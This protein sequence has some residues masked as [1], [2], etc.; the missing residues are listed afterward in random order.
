[1]MPVR[2]LLNKLHSLSA[3]DMEREASSSA[4]MPRALRSKFLNERLDV[5]ALLKSDSVTLQDLSRALECT[6]S[7]SGGMASRYEEWQREF[8]SD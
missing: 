8:G 5:D 6:K 2:R 7:S 3:S 1:M 4:H